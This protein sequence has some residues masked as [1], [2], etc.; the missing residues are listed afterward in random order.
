MGHVICEI[1]Q[2]MGGRK[3]L[4]STES[5]IGKVQKMT[6]KACASLKCTISRIGHKSGKLGK[7]LHSIWC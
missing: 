3:F 7:D 2:G 1:L 6:E 5:R 4:R